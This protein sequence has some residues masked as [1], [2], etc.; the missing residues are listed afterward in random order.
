MGIQT[1]VLSVAVAQYGFTD[2]GS[3][4][5][6]EENVNYIEHMVE[7][8]VAGFPGVDLIVTPEC[9]VQ[10][11]HAENWDKVL[12]KFSS[13]LIK[14]L[15][16]ICSE[17][18]IWGV[19][20]PW[21]EGDGGRC[22]NTVIIIDERGIIRHTY[23]KCYP[24]IPLEVCRPGNECPV[25]RGPK[26]S[27]IMTFLSSDGD[28]PEMWDIANQSDANVIIRLTHFMDPFRGPVWITNQGIAIKTGTY[29][30]NCNAVGLDDQYSYI[31][32]SSIADFNGN[33]IAEAP[34]GVAAVIK[35]DLY[36]GIIDYYKREKRK[37]NAHLETRVKG[38]EEK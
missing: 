8:V 27:R 2:A 29:V 12:L 31:G 33:S 38:E 17:Y 7:K 3:Y 32:A 18:S 9:S 6:V 24:W 26:G 10:G 36:P 19:F 28:Y 21:M 30:I 25:C 5:E 15:Q 4:D 14:R 13:P 11:V 1:E 23:V 22:E 34:A 16:K 35:A 20:N 37:A